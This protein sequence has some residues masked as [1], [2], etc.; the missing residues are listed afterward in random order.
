MSMSENR[1]EID[2][3]EEVDVIDFDPLYFE[4]QRSRYAGRGVELVTLLNGLAAIALLVTLSATEMTTL[5]REHLGDAMVVFGAGAALGLLSKFF[6]YL[7]RTIRLERPDLRVEGRPFRWLAVGAAVLGAVCFVAGL[8]VAR[9]GVTTSPGAEP[10][11]I[12]GPAEP[13]PRQ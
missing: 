13:A 1:A 10:T 12:T 2:I 3:R 7:R 11:A 5:G 8:V 4:K 9:E 6:A